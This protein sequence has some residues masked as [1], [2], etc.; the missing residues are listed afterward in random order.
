[1]NWP[2]EEGAADGDAG[3]VVLGTGAGLA[4]VAARPG[5][6][7]PHPTSISTRAMPAT[8][9]RGTTGGVTIRTEWFTLRCLIESWPG[10]SCTGGS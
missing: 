3:A 8:A 2:V 10:H 9:G 5:S 4:F 1:M 7:G 6:D